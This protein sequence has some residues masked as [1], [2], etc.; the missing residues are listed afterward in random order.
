VSFKVVVSWAAAQN[1]TDDYH[2]RCTMSGS[3]YREVV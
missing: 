2:V 3:R 1:L